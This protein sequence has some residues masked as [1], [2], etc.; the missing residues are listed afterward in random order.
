LTAV[1]LVVAGVAFLAGVSYRRLRQ[2]EDQ[3]D[4]TAELPPRVGRPEFTGYHTAPSRYTTPAHPPEPD[5]S[6]A[7]ERPAC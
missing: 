5:Q 2:E 4:D 6:P 7:P 3:A 1:L